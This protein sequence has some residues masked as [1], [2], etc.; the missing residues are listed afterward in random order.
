MVDI[1]EFT[2]TYERYTNSRDPR[3]IIIGRYSL[4]K[5]LLLNP[6]SYAESDKLDKIGKNKIYT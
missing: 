1:K 5:F 2:T 4:A 6:K 3:F